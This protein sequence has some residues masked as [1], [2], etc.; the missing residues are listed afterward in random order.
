MKQTISKIIDFLRAI[1]SLPYKTPKIETDDYFDC[2]IEQ[3]E[4][5]PLVNQVEEK[6]LSA[7]EVHIPETAEKAPENITN[8]KP[9]NLLSNKDSM[10]LGYLRQP[11]GKGTLLNSDLTKKIDFQKWENGSYSFVLWVALNKIIQPD[12]YTKVKFKQIESGY[13]IEPSDFAKVLFTNDFPSAPRF[14]L[15]ITWHTSSEVGKW[16]LQQ[17]GRPI[18]KKTSAYATKTLKRLINKGFVTKN[19]QSL[20]KAN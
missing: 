4:L 9:I 3:V 8:L 14:E 17:M 13:I 10:I 5:E 11:C 18:P 15:G 2:D 6:K 12:K 16:Y 1:F 20:Y 19:T 7:I